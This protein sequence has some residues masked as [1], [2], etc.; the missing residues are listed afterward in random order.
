MI[1]PDRKAFAINLPATHELMM[2]AREAVFNAI[3]HGHAKHVEAE[4]CYAATLLPL[5]YA[6]TARA[7]TPRRLSPRSTSACAEC[8]NGFIASMANLKSR[9]L[10]VREPACAWRFPAKRS[11]HDADAPELP[12]HG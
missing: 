2:V 4:I 10:P 3:L 11:P 12:R 7:S 6:T 1:T 8:G 5:R 9:A